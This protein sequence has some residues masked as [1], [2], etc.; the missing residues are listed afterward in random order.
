MKD[1]T[2]NAVVTA[3]QALLAEL[4]QEE[5]VAVTSKIALPWLKDPWLPANRM[6]TDLVGNRLGYQSSSS[7]ELECD[8]QLI[9]EGHKLL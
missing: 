8:L 6:R 5:L 1:K 3:I 4:S 7:N 2:I 9:K